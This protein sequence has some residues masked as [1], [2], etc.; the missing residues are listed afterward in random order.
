MGTL[1]NSS[2]IKT[3]LPANSYFR[4][5]YDWAPNG[6]KITKSYDMLALNDYFEAN[7]MTTS[8]YII[9]EHEGKQIEALTNRPEPISI[10][11]ACVEAGITY[12]RYLECKE[13][14]QGY[15]YQ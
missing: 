12:E 5:F 8:M 13:I 15:G 10:E 2:D 6:K 3:D 4:Y 11:E 9:I 1:Y 14:A 7:N